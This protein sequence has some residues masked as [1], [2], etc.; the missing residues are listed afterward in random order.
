MSPAMTDKKR[1]RDS[2]LTDLVPGKMTLSDR[3]PGIEESLREEDV[4]RKDAEA[5]DV[6]QWVLE[7]QCSSDNILHQVT[8][9][10]SEKTLKNVAGGGVWV[11]KHQNP[12]WTLHKSPDRRNMTLQDEH[13]SPMV[14]F[15]IT[16]ED[17]ENIRRSTKKR[18]I[19]EEDDANDED[20]RADESAKRDVKAMRLSKP[21]QDST[22][23]RG[24][25][26]I[27]VESASVREARTPVTN[28]DARRIQRPSGSPAPGVQLADL[29]SRRI[30]HSRPQSGLDSR[31][32]QFKFGGDVQPSDSG[33]ATVGFSWTPGMVGKMIPVTKMENATGRVRVEWSLD[34]EEESEEF[35]FE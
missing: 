35:V 21:S 29:P 26:N 18:K 24:G 14:M 11:F 4:A 32:R 33:T 7:F 2:S 19:K 15:V 34:G 16:K 31:P 13:G 17:D 9:H 23:K 28:D 27:P 1:K 3:I 25:D 22:G 20:H 6:R 5:V 12:K 30:T 10:T 8:K